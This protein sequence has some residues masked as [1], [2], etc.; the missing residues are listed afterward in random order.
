[1]K[2]NRKNIAYAWVLLLFFAV[3]QIMVYAHT[4]LKQG[5]AFSVCNSHTKVL[6]EKCDI[7]DVMH[8]N[9]MLITQ[10]VYFAPAV[11]IIYHYTFKASGIT[12]IQLIIAA[13]RA[14]PVA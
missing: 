3:G 14:P 12:P 4:H 11:A 5:H 2:K 6:K 9:H 13:G 7:C 10:H 8:N 1:M